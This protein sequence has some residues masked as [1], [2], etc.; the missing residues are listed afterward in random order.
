[1]RRN[2]LNQIGKFRHETKADFA[3]REGA[4]RNRAVHS[5]C[6]Y[7]AFLKDEGRKKIA[8]GKAIKNPGRRSTCKRNAKCSG[9]F[10]NIELCWR[11]PKS[12]SRIPPS[13]RCPS[14]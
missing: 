14:T 10:T 12:S 8:F 7:P 2:F 11:F 13:P 9:T 5:V 4:I 1:M 3:E 6:E